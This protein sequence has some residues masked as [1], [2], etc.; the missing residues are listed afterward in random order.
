MPRAFSGP[1]PMS[2]DLQRGAPTVPTELER[3]SYPSMHLRAARQTHVLSFVMRGEVLT[4]DVAHSTWLRAGPGDL[5]IHAPRRHFIESAAGP[6]TNCWLHVDGVADLLPAESAVV[7]VHNPGQWLSAFAELDE[8][9]SRPAGVVRSLRSLAATAHLLALTVECLPP[10]PT[11]APDAVALVSQAIDRDL[12]RGWNR[13]ELARLADV[14]PAHLDR[15]FN[16]ARGCSAMGYLRLRRLTRAQG[17]LR[18]TRLP[19][20]EVG[21]RCGLADPVYFSRAYR[22][23]FGLA[24]GAD[25]VHILN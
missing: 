18:D 2:V 7:A 19:V 5:M 21:R 10:M 3:Y 8:S 13:P 22:H 4:R 14:S 24:P 11:L 15:L 16:A 9:R 23:R 17:L 20:A 6:G 12:A 1:E 25:R